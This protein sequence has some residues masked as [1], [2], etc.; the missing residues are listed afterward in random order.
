MAT[1]ARRFALIPAAG[2]GMRFGGSFPKQYADVSGVPLLRRTID[3]L[4]G[5]IV[6]EAVFV[7]LARDDKLYADRVGD[8][9]G[10]QPLYC[11]GASRGE[12]VKNG[13]AAIGRHTTA[14]DWVLVHD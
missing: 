12:S 5:S 8:V 7:V 6:L 9:R 1:P 2:S 14:E 10:V 3:A 11:G 4:N 13:L